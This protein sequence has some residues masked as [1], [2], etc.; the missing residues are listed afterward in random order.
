MTRS[1]EDL[2]KVVLTK[3]SRAAIVFF[4]KSEMPE[5]RGFWNLAGQ[6]LDAIFV[7]NED[8]NVAKALNVN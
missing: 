2:D 7:L 3:D 5:Y 4:G 6:V 8:L 1:K